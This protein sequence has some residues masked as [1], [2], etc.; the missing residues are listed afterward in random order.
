[1][2]PATPST[3]STTPDDT[4][5][6]VLPAEPLTVTPLRVAHAPVSE[7]ESAASN[8]HVSDEPSERGVQVGVTEVAAA[9]LLPW[10]FAAVTATE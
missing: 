7:F 9:E 5:S 4:R 3:R 10:A 6:R 2:P 1:M 8:H